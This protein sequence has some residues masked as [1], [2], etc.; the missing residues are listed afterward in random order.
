MLT[1]NGCHRLLQHA[2]DAVLDQQRIVVGL[3]MDVRCAAFERGKNCCIHQAD[4]RRDVVLAGQPLDGDV[5]IRVV[6]GREHV[7]G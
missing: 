1:R 6:V 3:N 5:L 7:E 4:D 2:V